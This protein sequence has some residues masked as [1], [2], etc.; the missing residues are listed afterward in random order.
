MKEL[1]ALVF[2]IASVAY[3][4]VGGPK[5]VFFTLR[6]AAR[7]RPDVG[8]SWRDMWGLNHAN[9]IFFPSVLDEVGKKYQKLAVAAAA[10]VIVGVLC[11]LAAFSLSGKFS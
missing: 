9:L 6:L 1:L 11:G 7:R 5:L 8:P 3:L 10:K 2:F 4:V